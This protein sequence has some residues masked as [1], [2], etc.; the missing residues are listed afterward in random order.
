LEFVVQTPDEVTQA[1]L[2]VIGQG[3]WARVEPGVMTFHG[4]IDLLTERPFRCAVTA[5]A[6]RQ[7]GALTV[8]FT[9]LNF[10]DSGGIGALYAMAQD[11]EIALKLRVLEGSIVDRVLCYSGMDRILTIERVQPGV[12]PNSA[13]A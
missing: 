5:Q 4:D 10:L 12:P 2:V 8:D 7:G 6:R 1:D 3:L 9:P 11:P 13:V